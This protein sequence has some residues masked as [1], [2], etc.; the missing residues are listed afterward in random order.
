MTPDGGPPDDVLLFEAFFETA[1]DATVIVDASG[2]VVRVNAQLERLFG[3]TREEIVGHSIETLVPA[4]FRAAHASH[5]EGYF[6]DPRPRGM[7][8]G[9][10]L[11][12]L[13]KDGTEIPIEIS[14]SAVRTGPGA[15]VAAAIRDRSE[16]QRESAQRARLAAIIE[17]SNDAIVGESLD[18]TITTWNAGAARLFG[19]AASEVIGRPA[20]ILSPPERAEEHRNVLGRISR[21]ERVPPFETV[22]VRKD[23]AR[24]HVSIASSPV[25]DATGA[26]VG[27]SKVARDVTAMHEARAQLEEARDAAERSNRELEAFC[28]SVAHDLR[29]PLRG[30]NGFSTALLEDL[31]PR[32]DPEERG[33]L[34]RIAAS[35]SR[36]GQVIDALLSLARVTRTELHRTRVD[37]GALAEAV[38]QVLRESDPTRA[39]RLVVE[40]DLTVEADLPLCRVLLDNLLD[41]AWKFTARRASATVRLGARREPGAP[42]VF[43]VADDGAGFEMAYADRLFLPFQRLHEPHEFAGTGIGLATVRRIVE[44]HGGRVW[45]EGS[46][47]RGATF[48]F[49]LTSERPGGRP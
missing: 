15:L 17:S 39:L 40:G 9:L 34:E 5:R 35:A 46:P 43:F 12:G 42:P 2:L 36:M 38:V 32:L 4:R 49:T 45:G 44:R 18:G 41:N 22:R 6:G 28:Y 31:G 23:G 47:E 37:L 20:T 25:Y 27:A 10:E 21:G 30:I 16:R 8:S 26:L 48:F 7:G 11:F 19:W 33:Y 1:P 13:R 29:A 3:Y 14:L 24:V